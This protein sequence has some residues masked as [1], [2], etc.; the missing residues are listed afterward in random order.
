M[1]YYTMKLLIQPL[2]ENA[3]LHGLAD[4]DNIGIVK[5]VIKKVNDT[6]RIK[7]VDN[8]CGIERDKLNQIRKNISS[9]DTPD[10]KSLGLKNVNHRINL[11]YGEDYGLKILSKQNWGTAVYMTIPAQLINNR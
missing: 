3:V 4:L 2:A 1:N 11:H 6:I 9:F 7:V 5:I 8:G 10:S